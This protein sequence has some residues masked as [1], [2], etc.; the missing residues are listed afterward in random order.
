VWP[1]PTNLKV[2]PKDL[3]GQQVRDIMEG[4]QGQ[5]GVHCDTCHMPDPAR[6]T[7]NG[8]PVLNYADDSKPEKNAARLMYRMLDDIN[9]N[10]VSMIPNSGMSA[11]CGTCHRGR[12]AP[13]PYIPPR[14]E[15][16][17]PRPPQN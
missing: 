9:T 2:L 1:K 4:W 16:G 12:L 10:Y 5:L 11:T 8:R 13:E 14:E 17:P 3:D 15:H 7:P 6:K